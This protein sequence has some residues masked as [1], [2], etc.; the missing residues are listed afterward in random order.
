M[1]LS[2]FGDTIRRAD[3]RVYLVNVGV[4]LS[5]KLRSP[6]FPDNHFEFVPIPEG[7]SVSE[8]LPA[9]IHPIT[10]SD[11]YCYN[12]SAE[13][14]SLFSPKM[15]DDF[16]D[17]VVH[18]DPTLGNKNDGIHAAFSYGD[19]PYVTARASS[20]RHA[21]PGDLLFFLANL[22]A[23]DCEKGRF[24]AGQRGLYLIGLIEIDVIVEYSPLH[25]QQL[26]A[27]YTATSYDLL[28]FGRNAH[29]NHLLTM[30]HRYAEQPFTIFEGTHRSTRF[31]KAVPI[32][33]DICNTCLRDKNDLLF[34]YGK[35]ESVSACIGAYTRAVR[36]QFDLRH[37]SHRERFELFL[38]SIREYNSIPD[39]SDNI[40]VQQLQP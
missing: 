17:H 36:P 30:P 9:A 28:E 8:C 13:L 35:F 38:H 27:P 24:I 23:Y 1:Q 5:H 22:C 32:T 6:I 12:S 16:A 20:L 33:L 7:S 19:I 40:G 34:D 26:Y 4:N 25:G 11:L 29:V 18:Y 3:R 21:Q 31:V 39:L 37:V 10:Y 15:Q 2:I 14:R